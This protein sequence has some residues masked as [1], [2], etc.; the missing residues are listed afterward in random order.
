MKKVLLVF[1]FCFFGII[2][3]YEDPTIIIFGATGDLSAKKLFPAVYQL[4]KDGKQFKVI[5]IGRRALDQ[6]AF[7]QLVFNS[8]Q[9]KPE[10]MSF[11]KENITYFQTA[12]ED[13]DGYEKLKIYLEQ[14]GA[15]G[16]ILYYLATEPS[17]FTTI[18]Q[19]LKKTGALEDNNGWKR[20]IIE[21]P[22][23]YDLASAEQLYGEV[24]QYLK[25]EQMYLIDHYL[26]KEGVL[27]IIPLR[28][29]GMESIWNNEHIESV[30]IHLAEK[31]GIGTRGTFWE[32][33]GLLRD[34]VQNH[35]M[36]MLGL[37]AMETKENIHEEKV[38][39]LNATRLE[40]VLRAQYTSGI[41]DGEVFKGYLQE[42]GVASDSRTETFVAMRLFID[43]DR[44]AGVPFYIRAGKRLSQQAT[45]IFITFKDQRRLYIRVQPQPTITFEG[46]VI[47]EPK[48]KS[49]EA[50][51]N[52][53]EAALEGDQSLFV[54]IEEILASWK[55]IT[56]ILHAWQD[57]TE[58]LE[59]YEAGSYGPKIGEL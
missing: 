40:N 29:S 41:I 2:S 46:T 45:E 44:W 13:Q 6:D 4:A 12:F 31:I 57:S 15:N 36:Q 26:G 50:Y 7:H 24:S 53:I 3:A 5:G 14:R 34:V 56:P 25:P 42:E 27:N 19:N 48:S 54:A 23:G 28:H 39:V 20:V 1:L 21:K 16:N 51:E 32:G 47:V 52:L 58:A 38:K 9:N 49:R 10:T 22:F 43:N 59:T 8:L 30:E 35:V 11:I 33:T 17:Y 37:V 18:I 55:L